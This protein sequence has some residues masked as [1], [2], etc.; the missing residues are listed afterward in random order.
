MSLWS[1]AVR[2]GKPAVRRNAFAG[3]SDAFSPWVSRTAAI[4]I[5]A[6]GPARAQVYVADLQSEKIT[7]LPILRSSSA[8]EWSPDGRETRHADPGWRGKLRTGISRDLDRVAAGR[9]SARGRAETGL[10]GPCPMVA[11]RAGATCQRERIA[12]PGAVCSVSTWRRAQPRRSSARARPRTAALRACGRPKEKRSFI[13]T[14]TAVPPEAFGKRRP[15]VSCI[16][17]LICTTWRSRSDGHWLAFVSTSPERDALLMMPAAGGNPRQ[18]ASVPT[19]G[20][21]GVE[22]SRDR[23]LSAGQ[24]SGRKP[25][26]GLWRVSVEGGLPERLPIKL[27]RQ[28]GVSLHPDGRRVAFTRGAVQSEVWK[29]DL[30]SLLEPHR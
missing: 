12:A 6:G 21:S 14:R 15:T 17:A 8:P 20:I 24:H 25:V 13:F 2:D 18:L 16:T 10:P 3:I 4:I 22:W 5:T 1:I 28:G 11:G 9:Q 29:M 19:G 23:Q 27:D 26:A 30:T 7:E